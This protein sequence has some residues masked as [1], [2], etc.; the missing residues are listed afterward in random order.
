[1]LTQI[2]SLKTNRNKLKYTP[3][4][5]SCYNKVFLTC[6]SILIKSRGAWAL[7]MAR[8]KQV[9]YHALKAKLLFMVQMLGRN[10]VMEKT[11]QKKYEF[12]KF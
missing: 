4:K 3:Q 6:V 12:L 1:M 2:F 10:Y 9:V 8:G 11:E 7:H 5:Q